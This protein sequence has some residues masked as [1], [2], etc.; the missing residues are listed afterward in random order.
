MTNAEYGPSAE[1]DS[2]WL[3]DQVAEA[4]KTIRTLLRQLSKEQARHTETTRAYNL[5]VANLREAARENAQTV[6]EL[7]EWKARAERTPYGASLGDLPLRLSAD[8]VHAIRKAMA[9]LHHPD[10]GGD[11]ERMKH[12]NA[13]LDPLERL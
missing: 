10:L 6:R 11:P 8:E 4:H 9:R 7:N 1:S 5:T 12:W 13:I 3:R 2:V